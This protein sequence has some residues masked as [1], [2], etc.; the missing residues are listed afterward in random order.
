MKRILVFVVASRTQDK[1]GTNN[2]KHPIYIAIANARRHVFRFSP[3]GLDG[4]RD[5]GFLSTASMPSGRLGVTG[6]RSGVI[7]LPAALPCS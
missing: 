3:V 5:I 4:G 6:R 2:E 1:P 7:M